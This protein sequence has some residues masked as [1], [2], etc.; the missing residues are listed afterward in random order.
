LEALKRWI[1]SILEAFENI[2]VG[3]TNRRAKQHTL[4][5]SNP[6]GK[7]RK[8]KRRMQQGNIKLTMFF[9]KEPIIIFRRI[10]NILELMVSVQYNIEDLF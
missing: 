5:T 7:K 3:E 4:S 2:T 6:K 1:Q 8:R 9:F 10:S